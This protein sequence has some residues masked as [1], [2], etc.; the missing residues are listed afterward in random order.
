MLHCFQ[1]FD[2]LNLSISSLSTS[3]SFNIFG[4][5]SFLFNTRLPITKAAD[6]CTLRPYWWEY[7]YSPILLVYWGFTFIIC[8]PSFI[9]LASKFVSS[10][11]YIKLFFILAN[12]RFTSISF[13]NFKSSITTA[14]FSSF[15]ISITRFAISPHI[16]LLLFVLAYKSSGSFRYL[17]HL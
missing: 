10:F 9:A 1:L 13:L 4:T 15:A 8:T 14:Q 6:S 11:L 16:L 5:F 3:L 7:L 12:L 17:L 2:L